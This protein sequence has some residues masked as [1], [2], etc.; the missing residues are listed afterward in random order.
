ME[1]ECAW[2]HFQFDAGK[3]QIAPTAVWKCT[4]NISHFIQ[5]V[6]V[7]HYTCIHGGCSQSAAISMTNASYV[8]IPRWVGREIGI[9]GW[10]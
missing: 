7:Y 9:T 8:T 6:L 4:G 3:R 10:K 1:R 2:R 5:C